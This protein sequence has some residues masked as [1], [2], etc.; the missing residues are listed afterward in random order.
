MEIDLA[1]L[2]ID[3]AGQATFLW[4]LASVLLANKQL[5][6]ALCGQGTALALWEMQ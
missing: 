3:V 2:T 1:H 5:Q 4:K 6:R